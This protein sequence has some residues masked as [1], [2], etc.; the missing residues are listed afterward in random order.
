[1]H[2]KDKPLQIF[3]QVTMTCLLRKEDT[4]NLK[5]QEEKEFAAFVIQTKLRMKFIFCFIVQDMNNLNYLI[6]LLIKQLYDMQS[7]QQITKLQFTALQNI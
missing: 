2:K 1:M 7:F 3:L 6:N 5:S 4:P